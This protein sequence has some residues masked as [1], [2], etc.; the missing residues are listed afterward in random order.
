MSVPAGNGK[1]LAFLNAHADIVRQE[2]RGDDVVVR[3]MLPRHLLHRVEGEN[4]QV[5]PWEIPV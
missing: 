5:S 4:V 3:C 2:Y 1:L